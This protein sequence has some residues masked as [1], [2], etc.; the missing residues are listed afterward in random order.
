MSQENVEVVRRAVEALN[1]TGVDGVIEL[2][3]PE[4]DWIAIPGF[5]PDAQDFHGHAG[6]RAW[7]EKV[8]ETL[9][10]AHWQAEEIIDAGDHLYVALKLSAAG[11]AS[12]IPAEMTIFQAWTVR[13]AKLVRLESYL[14]REEALEAA[15]LQE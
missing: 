12:G 3:D 11:R 5:L 14:S 10:E 2:C 4:V 7:F 8:G 9:G 15:R 1:R 6:V 13:R